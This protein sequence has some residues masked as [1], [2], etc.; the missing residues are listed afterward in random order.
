M[1][2]GDGK[3]AAGR[4]FRS[5]IGSVKE[6]CAVIGRFVRLSCIASIT[7][8]LLILGN[9]LCRRWAAVELQAEPVGAVE[10]DVLFAAVRVDTDSAVREAGAVEVILDLAEVG[11]IVNTEGAVVKAGLLLVVGC[12]GFGGRGEVEGGFADLKD[13][14][15]FALGDGFAEE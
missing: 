12:G 5:W 15:V 10:P 2:C 13:E 4:L 3:S 1:H 9:A 11:G 7:G 8:M 6:S 14:E